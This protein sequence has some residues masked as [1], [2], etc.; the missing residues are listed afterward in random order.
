[1]ATTKTEKASFWLAQA[2]TAVRAHH[3]AQNE[4]SEVSTVASAR[5]A[6][7]Q[8]NKVLSEPEGIPFPIYLLITE[9]MVHLGAWYNG[10]DNSK[11]AAEALEEVVAGMSLEESLEK[12]G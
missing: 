1:M 8:I 5:I 6:Y 3:D 7:H 2:A 4:G 11:V 9:G 12:E 10:V